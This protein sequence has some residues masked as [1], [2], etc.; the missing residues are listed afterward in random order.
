M[1]PSC[2]PPWPRWLIV[3]ASVP[4]VYHLGSVALGAIAAPSGPWPNPD[5]VGMA[6]APPAIAPVH[7]SISQPYLRTVNLTHNAHFPSNRAGNPDAY[8]EFRLEDAAGE[9]LKTVRLPD[10]DAP[11]LVRQRQT[12][13]IRAVVED[14]PVMPPNSERIYPPGQLPPTVPI[15]DMTGPRKLALVEM[16]ETE[17]PRNR[18]VFRPTPWSLLV[19]RSCARHLC[20]VHGATA[21]RVTRY[22]RD[23]VS[24]EVLVAPQAIP[25]TIKD[26][27]SDYGR[28][29]K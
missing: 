26:L 28:F 24:P 6:G 22:S 14:Q 16:A 13:L 17:V 8:L 29:S 1:P 11:P 2:P 27:V 23:P 10:P 21:V 20:S 3:L 18:P 15:W 19:V 25:G 7:E 5:G 4:I 9:H 12:Q